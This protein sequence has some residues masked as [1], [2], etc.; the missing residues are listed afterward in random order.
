MPAASDRP[1][2][3]LFVCMGN[4]CRSPAAEGV[5]RRLACEAG[6]AEQV[7]IDSAGAG[8]WHEGSPPDDRM[9]AA[10][11]RRGYELTGR[12]RQITA[13]DIRRFDLV[14]IMDEQNRRDIRPWLP[15]GP[16]REKV[17]MF[18]EFCA[19]F[20]NDEVPDPYYGGRE[21]FDRVLDLLED[22]CAGVLEHIRQW[23]A[24]AAEKP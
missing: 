18:C 2:R 16:E 24:G 1:F 10:A 7:E 8:G 19:R 9:T 3:L 11:R 5:M 20:E 14:L 13:G 4:I 15:D 12:A 23:R 22:G 17:R 21:G 6:L